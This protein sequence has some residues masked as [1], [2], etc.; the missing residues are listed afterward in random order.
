PGVIARQ[1]DKGLG[2]KEW[3]IEDGVDIV[4]DLLG[5]SK[6]YPPPTPDNNLTTFGVFYT[7]KLFEDLP[8]AEQASL[9]S[10][11]TQ[12]LIIKLQTLVLSADRLHSARHGNWIPQVHRDALS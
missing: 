10:A 3:Y 8:A 1:Y 11:A 2:K 4:E 9:I 5:C 7:D 6:R 12:K